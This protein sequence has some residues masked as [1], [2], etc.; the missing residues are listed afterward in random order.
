MRA[1]MAGVAMMASLPTT[2]LAIP[3]PAA[4]RRM[5]CTAS[6]LKYR[7]SPPRPMVL[8]TASSPRALN[9]DWILQQQQRV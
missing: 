2:T 1:D 6:L 3:L 8:P 5:V 7:P 4:T 9:S